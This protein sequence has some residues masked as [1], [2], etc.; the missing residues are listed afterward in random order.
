M[1]W[2]CDKASS[3]ISSPQAHP[4]L[5]A[6]NILS[7]TAFTM[8]ERETQYRL[9]YT[10]E[11]FFIS[12]HNYDDIRFSSS[13]MAITHFLSSLPS[14]VVLHTQLAFLRVVKRLQQF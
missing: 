10:K 12:I 1:G 8:Q 4:S 2:T 9:A 5:A 13:V 11:T 3:N 14:V 7:V 6:Q